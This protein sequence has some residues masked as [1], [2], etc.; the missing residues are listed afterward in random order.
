MFSPAS[1]R[2]P[3]SVY[4]PATG[5]PAESSSPGIPRT[6]PLRLYAA[7]L[8]VAG[9]LLE[10]YLDRRRRAGRE[11]S[12]R[13]A[14]RRG[15]AS[16]A[17]P[18]GMLVWFHAASVGESMS[19]ARLVDR[20]LARRPGV[21]ILVTTGTVTSAAMVAQRLGDR[22]IH[23]YIPVDRGAWVGRFMAHWRPDCA[24][25]IESEIW[26]N[27]LRA[28]AARGIPA[29]LVNARMSARSHARWATAPGTIA[30]LLGAFDL[31]LAQTAAEAARLA[32]LGA[33]DVRSLG[34]LKYA[35]EPLS[36]DPALV[37]RFKQAIGGR[38][39]WLL[40][41]SHEGEEAIA[42]DA[43]L[44]LA[45][46][47]PDILTII[48]P[49]HPKRAPDI[50]RL[51]AAAG[52]GVALRSAGDPPNPDDAIYIV[53]IMGELGLWYRI[54]PIACIGGSLVPVGG[55][56][57]IE[58]A[59]LGCA[60]L[61]GPHM[62]SV[63]EI[64][65]ELHAENAAVAVSDAASLARAIARLI[66]DARATRAMTDAARRVAERNRDVI[67]RVFEALDPL[68]DRAA[69]ARAAR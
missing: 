29:A 41:S 53:D 61:H 59:Q 49:R 1:R 47:F 15:I 45:R 65:A 34:H 42:I 54:A 10:L 46:L 66:D 25:W 55:H 68:F 58:P 31:C 67:D 4:P 18:T 56:N 40:A 3:T 28:I 7:L 5:D 16:I 17:R 26:P 36:A 69:A 57:P 60:L 21:K 62:F 50:A 44:R 6:I 32:G 14:E 24:I 35:A 9:P 51:A 33:R 64:A 39:T 2:P 63:P 12:R 23:Q 37:A 20:L 11:D 48:A 52:L 22:I 13:L 19:I 38:K 43:H 30:A 27:L 8:T